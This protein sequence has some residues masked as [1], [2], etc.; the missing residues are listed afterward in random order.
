MR[1]VG[2]SACRMAVILVAGLVAT[3][4]IAPGAHASLPR[5]GHKDLVVLG[6]S[7]AAGTGNLPYEVPD[8]GGRSQYHSYGKYLGAWGLVR[9][10]DVAA[11]GGDKTE[12]VLAQLPEITAE[13]DV[14]TVQAIGNDFHFGRIA[15]LCLGAFCG[16][17]TAL[18]PP[19]TSPTIGE[20][21]ASIPA[22][23]KSKLDVLFAAIKA[24]TRTQPPAPRVLVVP[25]GN[26][27]PSPG[28]ENA[29]RCPRLAHSAR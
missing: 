10:V 17:T 26:P 16:R 28:T 1:R 14:V 29:S 23:A 8:C 21:I 13:T 7:F 2:R 20:I 15:A 3:L 18:Y 6:D 25:Y 9:S 4:V 5:L 22:D 11:C 27:F 24:A 12:E 19:A